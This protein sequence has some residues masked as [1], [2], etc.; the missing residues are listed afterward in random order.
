[1]AE[2]KAAESVVQESADIVDEGQESIV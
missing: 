1:M 2:P